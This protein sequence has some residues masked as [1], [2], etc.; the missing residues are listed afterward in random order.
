V[1]TLRQPIAALARQFGSFFGIGLFVALIHYAVLIA[2]VE[3]GRVDPV[4]AALA[5]YVI[6]G[7]VSYV[8]NRRLTYASHR[9]H[10]EATWRFAIVAAIGFLLTWTLMSL[11]TGWLGDAYYVLAQLVTT[12]IVLVWH[13]VAHKLWTFRR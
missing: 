13:F 12:A 2:L 8:L 4:R 7:V 1:A 9:P 6:G 5:G 3:L 10:A 11:L